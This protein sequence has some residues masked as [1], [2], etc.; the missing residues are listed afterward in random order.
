MSR[1]LAVFALPLI[2]FTVSRAA[3]APQAV[4]EK[5][6]IPTTKGT[7]LAYEYT[8]SDDQGRPVQSEVTNVVTAVAKTDAGLVVTMS[9]KMEGSEYGG[10]DTF[11][12]SEK[13][14]FTTGTSMTGPDIEGERS[15]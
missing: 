6:Y 4:P 1:L 7:V 5:P 12:L 15:W 9:H 3:P 14:L 13:G 10:T 11:L 2:L 8:T